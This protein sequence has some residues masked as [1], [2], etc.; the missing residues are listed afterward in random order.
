MRYDILVSV[1]TLAVALVSLLLCMPFALAEGKYRGPPVWA[2]APSP[3]AFSDSAATWRVHGLNVF[4][5][6]EDTAV[7]D[8]DIAEG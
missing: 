1:T 3:T 2:H 4:L 6:A 5:R 7:A 8:A